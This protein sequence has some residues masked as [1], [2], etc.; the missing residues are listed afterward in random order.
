MD[1]FFLLI[2]SYFFEPEY[3]CLRPQPLFVCLMFFS[4][5]TDLFHFLLDLF[6][7][8]N[9]ATNKAWPGQKKNLHQ[10]L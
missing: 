6:R 2:V 7:E 1:S 4:L 3:P 8:A 9:K 5:R 10:W